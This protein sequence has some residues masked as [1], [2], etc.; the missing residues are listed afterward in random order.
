MYVLVHVLVQVLVHVLVHVLAW[1]ALFCACTGLRMHWCTVRQPIG[2]FLL[3]HGLP[4][5]WL[6][7]IRHN[8][9]RTPFPSLIYTGIRYQVSNILRLF[10]SEAI[11]QIVPQSS[12][13]KA[14][15][16]YIPSQ[17]L[18]TRSYLLS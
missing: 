3:A 6:Y 8:I 11:A 14:G 2:Q 15:H 18:H 5:G 16:T 7:K 9:T 12:C 1:C 4:L 17:V 13:V 10:L